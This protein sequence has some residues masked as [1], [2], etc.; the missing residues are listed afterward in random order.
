ML[1]VFSNNNIENTNDNKPT[2]KRDCI[3]DFNELD[4]ESPIACIGTIKLLFES[5]NLCKL[6]VN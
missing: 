4:T 2:W 1:H 6:Q 5:N 3:N